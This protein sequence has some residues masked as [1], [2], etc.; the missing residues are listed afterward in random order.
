MFIFHFNL[1]E[2]VTYISQ[3]FPRLS[4]QLCDHYASKIQAYC[5][6]GDSFC[7]SGA[8]VAAHLDY[9][10]KYNDAAL[11]FVNKMLG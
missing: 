8:D 1:L 11:T 7:D 2:L 4:N 6:L 3:L 10:I 9:D 5:D